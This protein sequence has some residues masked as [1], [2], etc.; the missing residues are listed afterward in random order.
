M[1]ETTFSYLP[2]C[3][4]STIR[5][6]RQIGIWGLL[7]LCSVAWYRVFRLAQG[8][9]PVFYDLARAIDVAGSVGSSTPVILATV[10]CALYLSLAVS[11]VLLVTRRRSGEDPW[12]HPD[13]VST[14]YVHPTFPVFHNLA[15]KVCPWLDDFW[16]CR[17]HSPRVLQRGIE[18]VQFGDVAQKGRIVK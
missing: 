14:R 6:A 11:G 1:N 5:D 9:I 2:S 18:D 13:S 4:M 10:S 17:A 7:D 16:D 12:L 8:K 15:D 3:A